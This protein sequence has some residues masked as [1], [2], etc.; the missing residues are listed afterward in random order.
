MR[1]SAAEQPSNSKAR[2][3]WLPIYNNVAKV[4]QPVS[5]S[6]SPVN[7]DLISKYNVTLSTCVSDI[8]DIATLKPSSAGLHLLVLLV[9]RVAMA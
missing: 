1:L 7:Y 9:P 8:S 3:L 2:L 4:A 5:Q 6:W